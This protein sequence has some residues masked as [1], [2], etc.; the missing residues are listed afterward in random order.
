MRGLVRTTMTVAA[1]GA[2]C[3]A[4][5]IELLGA[6]EWGT[7]TDSRDGKTYKTV[8]IGRQTWMAENLNY[9]PKSGNS[10]CYEDSNSYC[11]KYGRLYDWNTAMKVC[12]AGWH[13]P[14]RGEWDSL[15]QAAGGVRRPAARCNIDWSGAGDTLKARR[16][17]YS[18]YYNGNGTDDYG[19]SALPGGGYYDG[20]F[21]SVGHSGAWWTAKEIGSGYAYIRYILSFSNHVT[22]YHGRT[23]DGLSVRCLRD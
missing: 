21:G 13:L 4:N 9:Q 7:F 6:S 18:G 10:W 3:L 8:T 5:A 19:F 14:S 2:L 1:A 12:P 20:S 23:G 22:E 17:W 11:D 16:G 15:G